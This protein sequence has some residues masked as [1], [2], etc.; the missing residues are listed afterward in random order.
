MIDGQCLTKGCY[1]VSVGSTFD[2][3]DHD[4]H[5]RLIDPIGWIMSI[6]N[7]DWGKG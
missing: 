5:L 1:P 7:R 2:I 4:H 6:R 3:V